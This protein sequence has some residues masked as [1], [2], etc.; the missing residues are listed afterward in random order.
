MEFEQTFTVPVS[1][2]EAWKVLQD[3]E[4]IAPCMPGATLEEFSGDEF[5]GQVKVKLGP[6]TV[7][8]R[9]TARFIERDESARRV[10]IEASGKEARGAGT[11]QATIT[12]TMVD[13]GDQTEVKVH[14]DL[15]I[16]GRPAQF[17]RG[18]MTDVAGKLLDQFAGCLSDELDP[19]KVAARDEA[20][21]ERPAREEAAPLDL[22]SVAG[23]PVAK[24]AL[25]VLAALAVLA[26]LVW[27]SRR[28]R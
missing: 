28:R 12:S 11:A 18:V 23:A 4:R 22:M 13:R 8:Y 24:R 19:G 20:L 25:P 7:T 26:L 10:A 14:T 6:M 15:A 3:I 27:L 17:G 1:V 9:G 16:T 5:S 2:D 21:G